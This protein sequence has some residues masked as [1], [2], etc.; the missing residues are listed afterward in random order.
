MLRSQQVPSTSQARPQLLATSVAALYP[1]ELPGFT[2]AGLWPCVPRGWPNTSESALSH[3]I[4]VETAQSARVSVGGC[5][6]VSAPSGILLSVRI[7][8]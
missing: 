8:G 1:R 3:I 2:Q 6:R 7:C 4:P 5:E